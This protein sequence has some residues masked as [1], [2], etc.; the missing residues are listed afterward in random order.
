[1]RESAPPLFSYIGELGRKPGT[2][3]VFL[4]GEDV[5]DEAFEYDAVVGYVRLRAPRCPEC[6]KRHTD[7]LGDP[8][9]MT[10]FGNV[11]PRWK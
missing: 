4:D 3:R 1:M 6:N 2:L 7:R 9:N 10:V 11:E 8:I 5:S